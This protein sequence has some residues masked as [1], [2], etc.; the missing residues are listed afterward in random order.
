MRSFLRL[1][2]ALLIAVALATASRARSQSPTQRLE[3]GASVTRGMVTVSGD[4]ADKLRLGVLDGSAALN[5]YLLRSTSS[6]MDPQRTGTPAPMIGVVLPQ[7]TEVTN[8]S[9][10]FGQND[11]ALWQGKG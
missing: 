1:P 9:L 10:P 4:S 6:L 5:G 3:P 7:V 2:H 11:G 8:T